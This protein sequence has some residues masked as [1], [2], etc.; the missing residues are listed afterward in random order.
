[1]CELATY[2]DGVCNKQ[3]APMRFGRMQL[4]NTN[5]ALIKVSNS[6]DMIN[7][8]RENNSST[9]RSLRKKPH[10]TIILIVGVSL[11]AFVFVMLALI[12][13]LIYVNR[14]RAF[15]R[16]VVSNSSTTTGELIAFTYEELEKVT[17]NFKEE[18]GR[19][20]FETIFKG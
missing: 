7:E 12:G 11:T 18:V 2:K 9:G 14:F 16:V 19:G 17:S 5:I 1:M 8:R 10:Q 4:D 6:T 20:A 15:K 13:L 3:K